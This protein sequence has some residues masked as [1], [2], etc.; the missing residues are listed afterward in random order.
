MRYVLAKALIAGILCLVM[1]VPLRAQQ[2]LPTALVADRVT[3]DPVKERLI[4]SGNVQV[5][6]DGQVLNASRITYE[7]ATGLIFA[8]GPLVIKTDDDVRI[9]ANSADLDTKLETA[10][11]RGARLVLAQNFQFAAAEARREV[12]DNRIAVFDHAVVFNGL[13]DITA[14]ALLQFVE[15]ELLFALGSGFDHKNTLNNCA[16][17]IAECT[18]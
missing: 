14:Q 6:F 11:I 5:I 18:G 2:T 1:A 8:E 7:R 17:F 4:A 9:V 3:Y 13:A 15:L 12:R 16:R 10:L